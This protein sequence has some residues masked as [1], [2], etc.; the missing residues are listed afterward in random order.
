MNNDSFI[1]YMLLCLFSTIIIEV[2][3]AILCGVRDKKD[4]LNIILV[5]AF[6]NPLVVSI[7]NYANFAIGYENS[8]IVLF[9]ME[10]FAV[11]FEGYTYKK[12][13]KY[14]K[15]EAYRFSLILNVCSY[16]IGLVIL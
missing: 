9:L 16:L 4:I 5:N 2:L 6:T 14:K 8:Y 3:V 10:I 15:I 7:S 1:I 11:I 13:F 12:F